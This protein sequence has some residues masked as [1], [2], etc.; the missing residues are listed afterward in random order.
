MN[1]YGILVLTSKFSDMNN[2]KLPNV[3]NIVTKLSRFAYRDELLRDVIQLYCR[4]KKK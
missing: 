4:F 1:I 3:V 2:A